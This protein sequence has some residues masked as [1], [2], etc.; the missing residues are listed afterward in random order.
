MKERMIGIHISITRYVDDEPQPGLVE[1]EFTDAHGHQHRFVEKTVYL[2]IDYLYSTS[3]YP[4]HGVVVCE[5]IDQRRDESGQEIISVK[6]D[7]NIESTDGL[8]Q[9]E[10]TPASL[11]ERE[12]GSNITRSWDGIAN[13]SLHPLLTHG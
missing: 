3:T 10:V 8:T 4:C 7:Y 9:F 1:G 11:V 6:P 2:S 5:I 12:W 13:K